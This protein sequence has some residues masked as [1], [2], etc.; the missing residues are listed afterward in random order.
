M[1]NFDEISQ[2]TAEIKLLPASKN[3]RPP[4]RISIFGF[5]FDARLVIGTSFYISLPNFVVIGGSAAEF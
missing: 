5:D 3:G 4:Y 1:P 2:C